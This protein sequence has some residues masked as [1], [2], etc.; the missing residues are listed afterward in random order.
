MVA[1]YPAFQPE[2]ANNAYG[3]EGKVLLREMEVLDELALEAGLAPLTAFADNRKT[4]E[5]F[6]G[7]PDE[8]EELVG[9]FDEWFQAADGLA[10]VEGLLTFIQATKSAEWER[11]DRDTVIGAL[12]L[13][14]DW[15]V[16]A[17]NA[18]AKFRFEVY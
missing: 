11:F 12:N 9:P 3:D 8:L 2:V 10:S 5:G 13:L 17:A 14:R 15:L 16:A 7:D 6:D 1:L 4:P 18:N